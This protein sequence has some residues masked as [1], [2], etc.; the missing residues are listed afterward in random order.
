MSEEKIMPSDITYLT[1]QAMQQAAVRAN[2]AK[3]RAVAGGDTSAAGQ[4]FNAVFNSAKESQQV[5]TAPPAMHYAWDKD[6]AAMNQSQVPAMDT[7]SGESEKKPKETMNDWVNFM[8]HPP[9]LLK[10][11]MVLANPTPIG[12]ATA[13][14]SHFLGEALLPKEKGVDTLDQKPVP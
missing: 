12:A 3:T 5:S 10:I 1:R 9:M 4:K 14:A 7:N 2:D 6:N 11:G 13:V 8:M